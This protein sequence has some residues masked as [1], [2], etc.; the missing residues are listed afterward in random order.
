MEI[1]E[2]LKPGQEIKVLT[3]KSSDQ[4]KAQKYVCK[5]KK[6]KDDLVA[7]PMD[8]VK[9]EDEVV[10]GNQIMISWSPEEGVSYKAKGKIIQNKALPIIVVRFEAV[11]KGKEGA[12]KKEE[13]EEIQDAAV[14]IDPTFDAKYVKEVKVDASESDRDSARIG[15]AFHIHYFIIDQA[16][17][18]KKKKQYL[19]KPSN[20]RRE[21]SEA[22]VD[23]S[24]AEVRE[25]LVHVDQAIAEVFMDLYRKYAVMAARVFPKEVKGGG[26][27]SVATCV[28]VSG[29]G[30]QFLSKRQIKPGTVLKFTI[31]P[32]ASP[33]FSL[34]VMGE[35]MRVEKKK[36]PTDRKMK[37]AYGTRFV[38]IHE[39]DREKIIQYTFKRQQ[40]I[41]KARRS[42]A[43]YD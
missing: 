5:V 21:D 3:Y 7:I 42:K 12:V 14:E 4:E 31:S 37:Y 38:A 17:V 20:E 26:E 41:L 11:A 19:A 43:G 13:P 24:E 23:L 16:S 1:K 22:S 35:V 32:P 8:D 27:E 18:G 29:T 2:V 28:D 15:D 33:P 9:D 36:D 39:D 6:V 34:N 10:V 25:K 30:L 40:E